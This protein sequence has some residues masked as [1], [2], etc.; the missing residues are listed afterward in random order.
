[1]AVLLVAGAHLLI[2]TGH[3][4]AAGWSGITGVCVFFVH[5]SLVLMWSLQRDGHT[6]RFY[7][8]RA[9]RIYP[10]WL[11]VLALTVL[12]RLPISPVYVPR[13]QFF[14]PHWGELLANAGLVFNFHY[15]TRVVGAS[16]TLP[17][18]VDMYLFLPLLFLFARR[19]RSV[20]PLLTL[21]LCFMVYDRFTH[22]PIDS[23]LSMCVPFF[24]PGIMAF[25]LNRRG[26]SRQLPAW[27]FPLWFFLLVGID[28]RDGS[29]RQSWIFALV[30]GCSLPWFQEMSWRP[31]RVLS[32]YVA[33][34][35]YG[36]YLTHMA[37]IC[38]SVYVLR[39]HSM[40][41]RVAAFVAM[42]TGLPV[43]FYHVVEEPMIRLGAKLAGH[44]GPGR[45]PRINDTTLELE[46]AP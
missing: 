40:A 3:N 17:V 28:H 41:V 15:G 29:F 16:W 6:A 42:F 14:A 11:V 12:V 34:Y 4:R 5:T 10:L 26:V 31:V 32:H 39:T 23:A 1:M 46:M 19:L 36:V 18:E 27:T 35:S 2:Y 30:L 33:R 25:V 13:F 22:A 43:V 8:R 44:M 7:L 21:D 20:W 37:A 45:S 9:F 24:L 38:V